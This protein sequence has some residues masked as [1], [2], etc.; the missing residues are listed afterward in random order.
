MRWDQIHKAAGWA[1]VMTVFG[2][3]AS[4]LADGHV[5][6]GEIWTLVSAAGGTFFA[7]LKDHPQAGDYVTPPSAKG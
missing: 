1:A 4:V 7:Y 3:V 2:L 5:T 6:S